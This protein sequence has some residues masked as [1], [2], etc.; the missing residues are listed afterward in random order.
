M[1]DQ[2]KN[3]FSF[4]KRLKSFVYA[5]KGI[6]FVLKTQHN[7]WIHLFATFLAVGLGFVFSISQ[8]EWIA[9]IICIGIVLAFET[10]N[11]SIELL[12][13]ARFPDY[14]K[15]A[16]RIKDTAAGAVFIVAMAALAVGLMIFLPKVIQVLA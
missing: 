2:T 5:F 4:Q 6:A 8:N 14:D 16:E 10:M 1:V 3:N 12:C 9:V 7:A 13:D 15:R 11:T